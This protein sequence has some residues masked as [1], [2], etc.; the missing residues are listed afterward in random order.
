[1]NSQAIMYSYFMDYR[2]TSVKTF[3]VGGTAFKSTNIEH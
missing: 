1:M 2:K 3:P